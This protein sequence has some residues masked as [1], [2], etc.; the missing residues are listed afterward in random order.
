MNRRP[1]PADIA[2][3][4]PAVPVQGSVSGLEHNA[5][6]LPMGDNDA[7]I[8]GLGDRDASGDSSRPNMQ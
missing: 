5:A 2:V 8:S 3:T 1:A 7:D 6:T 4:G